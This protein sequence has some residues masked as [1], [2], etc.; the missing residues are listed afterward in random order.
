MGATH[1]PQ[2]RAGAPGRAACSASSV[3]GSHTRAGFTWIPVHAHRGAN[4]H[5]KLARRQR[6]PWPEGKRGPAGSVTCPEPTAPA[7]RLPRER[8]LLRPEL[9]NCA[10]VCWLSPLS[11]PPS[12]LPGAGDARVGGEGPQQRP[13]VSWQ[14][15]AGRARPPQSAGK[16]RAC[17]LVTD[18]GCL[19]ACP[20][21]Q[22]HRSQVRCESTG[23]ARLAAPR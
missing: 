14:R 2:A 15:A 22:A 7:S 12:G 4:S 17:S 10:R 18:K 16:E 20:L 9:G 3:N 13:A 21:R 11:G 19:L 1:A 6:T 8:G 5:G 23:A